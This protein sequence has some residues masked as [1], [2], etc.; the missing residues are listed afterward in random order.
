MFFPDEPGGPSTRHWDLR[1][2]DRYGT[3][4]IRIPDQQTDVRRSAG[5]AALVRA[6]A[7][8]LADGDVEPYD[9]VLYAKQR[10]EAATEPP[11]P[12]EVE[13]L[14]EIAGGDPLVDELLEQPQEADRQLERGLPAAVPDLAERSLP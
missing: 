12:A 2:N 6:L 13:R 7:I 10:L 11:D 3:L 5:F 9:E 1:P 8:R 4:E 14:A